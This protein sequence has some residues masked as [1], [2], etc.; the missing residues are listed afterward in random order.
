MALGMVVLLACPA[1]GTAP[2]AKE[3]WLVLGMDAFRRAQYDESLELANAATTGPRNSSRI[4]KFFCYLEKSLKSRDRGE[5]LAWKGDYKPLYA[6][7]RAEDVTLLRGLEDSGG[8]YTKKYALAFIEMALKQITH[9]RDI[10]SI[11]THLHSQDRKTAYAA[12]AALGKVL[13]S[14]RKLVDEG[15]TLSDTDQK[16]FGDP[17]IL[18]PLVAMLR[19]EK[20]AGEQVKDFIPEAFRGDV[21][22]RP[23]DCLVYIEAPALAY[24]KE[25]QGEA[26]DR[27][28]DAQA[29]IHKVIY[30]RIKKYPGS[31]WASATGEKPKAG[32]ATPRCTTC[33]LAYSPGVKHCTCGI[34]LP[35]P[36]IEVA[37]AC[38]KCSAIEG[39]RLCLTCGRVVIG[40]R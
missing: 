1:P 30:R 26:G 18:R 21:A 8:A 9:L 12:V 36:E 27:G 16:I 6:A 19:Y 40:E 10:D 34:D 5:T 2:A 39:G 17:T 7:I 23:D 4:V 3:E 25:K 28:V 15:G 24:L 32:Y 35:P 14:R 22:A 11:R 33:N 38:K 31:T 13:A 20:S 37:A 29:T